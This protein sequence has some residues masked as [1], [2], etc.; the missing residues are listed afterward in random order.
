MPTPEMGLWGGWVRRW[1]VGPAAAGE[2]SLTGSLR[3]PQGRGYFDDLEKLFPVLLTR[4]VLS[5]H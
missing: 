5:V 3:R 1:R 2:Q 4:A